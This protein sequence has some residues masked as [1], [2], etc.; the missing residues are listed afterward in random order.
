MYTNFCD[1]I[2]FDAIFLW[3]AQQKRCNWQLG[4]S[5]WLKVKS[6]L[7]NIFFFI[8]Y[9]VRIFA[10]SLLSLIN[11]DP[12]VRK[13]NYRSFKFI[14]LLSYTIYIYVQCF[15]LC[16]NLMLVFHSFFFSFLVLFI[17]FLWFHYFN[18]FVSSYFLFFFLRKWS[19][20]S[21]ISLIHWDYR[22][23]D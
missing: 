18:Y 8:F 13:K 9:Y 4:K 7:L 12:K 5:K 22:L 1:K 19:Y 15:K 11:I 6:Q 17:S 3:N 20:T 10:I 23:L 2:Q 21:H 16:S 14:S